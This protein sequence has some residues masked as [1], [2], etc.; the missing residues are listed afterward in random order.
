MEVEKWMEKQRKEGVK[1]GEEKCLDVWRRE[2]Y[3][4]GSVGV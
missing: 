1:E 4:G 2:D 3:G